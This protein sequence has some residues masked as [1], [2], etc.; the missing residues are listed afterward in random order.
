[1]QDAGKHQ[2]ATWSNRT[3]D[4][5]NG[6]FEHVMEDIGH[7]DVPSLFRLPRGHIEFGEANFG[8]LITQGILF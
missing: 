3:I 2:N 5:R 7:N 6:S 8:R 1:M 4:L